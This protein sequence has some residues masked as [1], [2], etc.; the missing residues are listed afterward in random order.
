MHIMRYM[1]NLCI[2]GLKKE[3]KNGKM[4]IPLCQ[5]YIPVVIKNLFR[6]SGPHTRDKWLIHGTNHRKV[7]QLECLELACRIF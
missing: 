2:K 3:E 7:N 1:Q 5:T 6:K 4:R